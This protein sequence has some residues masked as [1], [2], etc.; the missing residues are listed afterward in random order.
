[1]DNDPYNSV[2][3]HERSQSMLDILKFHK[4]RL[5]NDLGL[6]GNEHSRPGLPVSYSQQLHTEPSEILQ[7]NSSASA[8]S[9]IPK[10]ESLTLLPKAAFTLDRKKVK[11]LRYQK[12]MGKI[13]T[14]NFM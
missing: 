12:S 2:A 10:G 13:K 14:H 5:S 9:V 7:L 3:E 1:M 11:N 6:H 8:I 4:K